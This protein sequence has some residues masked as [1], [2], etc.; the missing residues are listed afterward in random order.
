M[1]HMTIV[2]TQSQQKC[3]LRTYLALQLENASRAGIEGQDRGCVARDLKLSLY[4]GVAGAHFCTHVT[5]HHCND[6]VL[7]ES[8]ETVYNRTS[9]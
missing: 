3:E 2:Q 7:G 9:S 8:C 5:L 6:T 1:L 4:D